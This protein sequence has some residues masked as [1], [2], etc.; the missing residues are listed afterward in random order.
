MLLLAVLAGCARSPV[1]SVPPSS[2]PSA[3]TPTP[4]PARTIVVDTRVVPAGTGVAVP[5][6]RGV[7]LRLRVASPTFRR[8]SLAASYGYPPQHGYYA[9]FRVIATNTGRRTITIGPGNFFVRIR[10]HRAR[11]TSYDGNA[12][13]SGAPRQLDTTA[14][15]PGDSL[16]EPL[17]FDVGGRHGRIAFAP[18]R[19]AAV[20]WR[21]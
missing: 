4:A 3:G 14:L 8:T 13:Y 21:F 1:S 15:A 17:T 16:R 5:A 2:T 11:I 12:P 7:G 9:T 18:D 10:D 20:V 6:Q 19:S